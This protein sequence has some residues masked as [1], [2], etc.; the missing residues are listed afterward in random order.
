MS[1]TRHRGSSGEK[2]SGKRGVILGVTPEAFGVTRGVCPPCVYLRVSLGDPCDSQADLA[3]IGG[4][5]PTP[6]PA[7]PSR[8]GDR[9]TGGIKAMGP[10]KAVC[11]GCHPDPTT[12][13]VCLSMSSTRPDLP[14]PSLIPLPSPRPAA[15]NQPLG[16][17]CVSSAVHPG[18][19]GAFSGA[20]YGP[21][22]PGEAAILPSSCRQNGLQ[23]HARPPSVLHAVG[24]TKQLCRTLSAWFTHGR[25]EG[26]WRHW[27]GIRGAP[28]SASTL[29]CQHDPPP[30][31]PPC[32]WIR[33]VFILPR[34]CRPLFLLASLP[35]VPSPVSSCE[36][37][38]PLIYCSV[39]A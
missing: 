16:S 25:E 8:T 26:R 2:P 14:L 34:H 18:H 22:T 21:A 6:P 10:G 9:S 37:L 20:S 15:L 24:D 1:H 4:L 11:R 38:L 30:P 3:H 7:K 29:P 33:Q 31:P 27:R 36:N 23:L 5:G 32:S 39:G 35:E 12:P 28:W 19:S 17:L 13:G